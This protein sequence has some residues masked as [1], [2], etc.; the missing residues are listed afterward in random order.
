MATFHSFRK[1]LI[2]SAMSF[3]LAVAQAGH[4]PGGSKPTPSM[5]KIPPPV[6]Q[7]SPTFSRQIV[8]ISGK[9]VFED[10][11][12][13]PEP[14][15]IEKLCGG[16]SRLEGYTD[17]KGNFQIQL[18]QQPE[19]MQD[20][21]ESSDHFESRLS[22]LAGVNTRELVGCDLRASYPGFQSTTVSLGF[23][24][25]IGD[26]RVGT[27]VL[28]RLGDAPGSTISLTTLKAPK[29]AREAYEKAR[30]L[31]AKKKI[32]DAEVRLAK[33]V[34]IDPQFASAW[35]MLGA[36]HQQ[37]KRFDEASANY[38]QALS[39][40]PS[41]VNPY[42]GLAQISL[43]MGKWKEAA[44]F[45]EQLMKLNPFAYPVA[46]WYDALAN[47]NLKN[48][49]AAEKSARKFESLDTLHREPAACLLM[50]R[51]LSSRGDYAGAAGEDRAY[52]Q[53][54]PNAPDANAVR[55]DL[56]HLESLEA[57]NRQ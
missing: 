49:E 26:W 37:Q 15:A 22:P 48:V 38:S 16:S 5:P 44:Q 51:I 14:I 56:K 13:S 20:A 45:T 25:G 40:D 18:G 55:E 42:L 3:Q 6:V 27:L 36:I 50:S 1:V 17:A 10:G 57:T 43:I 52:L 4:G 28:K 32:S 9:V 7:Q 34:A 53:V 29:N 23:Q 39:A 2:I 24:P 21:S 41:F 33:A 8:V 54:S 11:S 46:Y 30:Q 19:A 12:P 31:L 47:Y 35:Y